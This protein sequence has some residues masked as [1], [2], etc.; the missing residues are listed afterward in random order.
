M[1]RLLCS[2]ILIHSCCLYLLIPQVTAAEYGAIAS[3]RFRETYDDNVF[4]EKV[5]DFEHRIT[6]S[7]ALAAVTENSSLQAGA[8]VDIIDYQ[9]HD[10]L[11][12]VDQY[13][14]ILAGLSPSPR[15]LLD[16]TGTYVRDT[17][18]RSALEETGIIADRGKR[19]QATVSPMATFQLTPRDQLQLFYKLNNT[20]Y[21][22]ERTRDY[23]DHDLRLS[24][25]HALRNER[26]NVVIILGGSDTDYDDTINNPGEKLKQ[27]TVGGVVGFDHQLSDT[28][29]F[30]L[31]AGPRYTTSEFRGSER[32]DEKSVG[33]LGDAVLT[34]R[35]ERTTV[36]MRANQ[37]YVPSTLGTNMNRTLVNLTVGYRLTERLGCRLSGFYRYSKSDDA[38]DEFK[39]RAF[40]VQPVL[41]YQLPW[42][43]NLRLGYSYTWAER[44]DEVANEK[45]TRNRV[46][47]ELRWV[48]HRPEWRIR[49]PSPL[50]EWPWR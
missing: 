21:E 22:D 37:G 15:L 30:R 14:Q 46:F 4:F 5:D 45:D 11:D 44:E 31:V 19:E 10:E 33:F 42:N 25:R 24:W 1:T 13:Y 27:R 6:P 17:T 28:S 7:L 38:E 50:V 41:N 34:W 36:S 47:L 12:T 49:Q 3:L 35:S 23:V 29:T 20:Q 26:T 32:D 8:S 16:V 39:N 40:A 2:L 43:M 48:I 18:F 9:R